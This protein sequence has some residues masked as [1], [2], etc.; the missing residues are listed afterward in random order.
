VTG[1]ALDLVVDAVC[2]LAEDYRLFG[3]RSAVDLLRR[4]GYQLHRDEVSVDRLAT[5]LA[6]HPEW[7]ASWFAWSNDGHGTPG[8][9]LRECGPGQFEV[10]SIDRE[11]HPLPLFADRVRA[12]AEYVH[13]EIESIA[14]HL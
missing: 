9:Y 14:E 5:C 3:D 10:G 7:V 4:S 11:R 8:W 13:R 2:A 12:C 1:A 6:D